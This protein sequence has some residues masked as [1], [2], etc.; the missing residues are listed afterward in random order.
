MQ[1]LFV[2]CTVVIHEGEYKYES[3]L[4]E[5]TH[6]APCNMVQQT[7]KITQLVSMFTHRIGPHLEVRVHYYLP[8]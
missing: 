7:K 2:N 3:L 8:D 6:F 4:Q 5:Y 1:Q